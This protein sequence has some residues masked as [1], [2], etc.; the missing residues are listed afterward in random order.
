MALIVSNEAKGPSAW[1]KEIAKSFTIPIKK[2]IDSLN[3][4]IAG[5]IAMFEMRRS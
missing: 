5:S 1:A 3:A 2:D 4:A